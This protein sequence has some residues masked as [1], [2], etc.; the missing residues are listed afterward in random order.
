[1]RETTKKGAL[2]HKKTVYLVYGVVEQQVLAYSHS[3]MIIISS[4]RLYIFWLVIFVSL[5]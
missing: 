1:M 4:Y 2:I 3:F 5:S